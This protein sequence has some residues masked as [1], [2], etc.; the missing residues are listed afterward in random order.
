MKSLHLLGFALKTFVFLVI[1]IHINPFSTSAQEPCLYQYST[2]SALAGGLYDSPKT[3]AEVSASGNFGIGT[4][5]ALDGELILLN[6]KVYKAKADSTNGLQTELVKAIEYSPFF[7]TVQFKTDTLLTLN[8][9][10][11]LSLL[12]SILNSIVPSANIIYAIKVTANFNKLRCR[13]VSKQTKPYKKLVNAVKD[14]R[15]WDFSNISATLIGIYMP[16]YMKDINVPGYHWHALSASNSKGGHLLDFQCLSATIEI[17][18]IHNY[19]LQLPSHAEF[20]K[21]QLKSS[22]PETDYI[23]K[24]K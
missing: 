18:Y 9:S 1:C 8:Q 16:E 4:F 7:E 24:N 2:F 5:N 15:I 3:T 19:K 22:K 10:L 6:S 11:N 23:E 17:C 20:N 13:S 21:M 12:D 14:Q